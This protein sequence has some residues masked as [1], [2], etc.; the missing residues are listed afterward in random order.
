[1]KRSEM[2]TGLIYAVVL[3][4]RYEG[5]EALAVPAI[6]EETGVSVENHN[7]PGRHGWLE[8]RP[9]STTNDGVR[10]QLLDRE[11]LEPIRTDEGFKTM[12]IKGRNVVELWDSHVATMRL[13]KE[14]EAATAQRSA[15][16]R[17]ELDLWTQRLGLQSYQVPSLGGS[18]T[19]RGWD[20][21]YT[22]NRAALVRML[23]AAYA[24]GQSEPKEA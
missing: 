20:S 11:T 9:S 16:V 18:I 17:E 10:I 7:H 12:V 23:E 5:S 24:L 15:D 1:M 21:E 6:V 2:K 4:S 22:R 13:R 3:G 8:R 19:G 14:R